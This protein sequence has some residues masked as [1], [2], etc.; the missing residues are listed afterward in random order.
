MGIE[1]EDLKGVTNALDFLKRVNL[2]MP[3]EVGKRVVVV[4]GGNS[5]VDAAQVAL[6]MGA[7][8]VRLLYRRTRQEMPAIKQEIQDAIDE[9]IKLHTLTSPL[10]IIGDAYG[11]ALGM[12]C[13]RMDLGGFDSSGR[14][15][16]YFREGSRFR[17]WIP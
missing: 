13:S 5:A 14:R 8:E 16:P 1:G 4:G 17:M 10:R 12:E 3:V 2:N 6:R 9:G 11:R 7:G 15:R